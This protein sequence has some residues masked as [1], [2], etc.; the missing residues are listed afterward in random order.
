[1]SREHSLI[2]RLLQV[3]LDPNVK[4]PSV[5]LGSYV[6]DNSVV[7][8][9]TAL[10]LANIDD[11]FIDR[12]SMKDCNS[13]QSQVKVL[14]S[15]FEKCDSE[16]SRSGLAPDHSEIC[17]SLLSVVQRY[18]STVI[19]CPELFGQ[20]ERSLVKSGEI[21]S[22]ML[23]AC[24]VGVLSVIR[25]CDILMVESG[26]DSAIEFTTPILMSIVNKIITNRSFDVCSEQS[27]GELNSLALFLK[28]S[29]NVS[30]LICAILLPNL[31]PLNLP[32]AM[33]MP[34][35]AGAV[36]T[37]ASHRN[38]FML[39]TGTLIGRLLMPSTVDHVLL[40]PASATANC[41]KNVCFSNLTRR[42]VVDLNASVSQVRAQ[43]GNVIDG[44]LSVIE[45]L[46][47]ANEQVRFAVLR[48]FATAITNSATRSTMGWA[49]QMAPHG[50]QLAEHLVSPQAAASLGGSLGRFRAVT[51][52]QSVR[53]GGLLSSGTCLNLAWTIFEMCKPIK[54][55]S[56]LDEMFL[57]SRGAG[58][59][60]GA[61]LT[62]ARLGDAERVAAVAP[63]DG[64]AFKTQIFWL[65]V[66]AIHTLVLPSTKEAEMCIQCASVFHRDKKDGP[67]ND[68]YGEFHCF[69]A[70][71]SH[72]RFVQALAHVVNLVLAMLVR[73]AGSPLDIR[74]QSDTMSD[75]L[76]ILPSC[77]MEEIVELLE[78][79]RL[80][81]DVGK[82]PSNR[83]VDSLETDLF[84]QFLIWTLGS[85]QIRNPN[86]RGKAAK[87]LVSLVKEPRFANRLSAPFCV[88]NLL[89][90]CIRVFSAVEKTKQS[91][92]DIRM[93]VKFEL[94][95][96]IQQLFE[97]LLNYEDHRKELSSFVVEFRE[98]FYKFAS[99]LLN[100]TTYLL[101]EGLDTLIAIRAGNTEATGTAGL[102]VDRGVEEADQ[103]EAGEDMY[104]RSRHDPKE[105]CKQYMRMGHQTVSTLHQMCKQTCAVLVDDK[106]V[107]DQMIACC[108]DPCL[109]RLVGP[110]C[111][112]L[113]GSNS[114]VADFTLFE[115]DP[116]KLL[117]H[118]IEMYVYLARRAKERVAKAVSEDLRYYRPETL[119]KAV[120]I[121]R[122]EHLVSPEILKEFEDL[123]KCVNES[124]ANL[125]DAMSGVEV[126]DEYLDPVMAEIM[127]D[128]VLLPTSNNIMD[129][130]HIMRIILSDDHDPFNRQPL[131]PHDLIPQPELQAQIHAFCH[132]HNIP[133]DLHN[134]DMQ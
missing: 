63:T 35:T 114:V 56:V 48:W 129:R 128:P 17:N 74:R 11:I 57:V 23:S 127:V 121:A 37:Q 98:D 51:T 68:A 7:N 91:Y 102:G 92:Y 132:K 80:M 88:S 75:S 14:L 125:A 105:H 94:R 31:L 8:G 108:L 124:A 2:S 117:N 130:K 46:V 39:Q 3:S 41:A 5:Y 122:R 49:Q 118:I 66:S 13:L 90:A 32:M 60:L 36:P 18:I 15:I 110:K 4:G 40:P 65:A 77:M 67:M 78:F 12:L 19:Q 54:L 84:L 76:T 42:T 106:V 113:K 59:L 52:M 69:E 34:T 133:M 131:K 45:P 83:L 72:S 44:V 71:Y 95:I 109:D 30:G 99:Q 55:D 20:A 100:D 21:I 33:K 61:L 120:T 123:A 115:F 119:R 64:G 43:L 96:P 24:E 104:R 103:N 47:R 25:I 85:D 9:E 101:E 79:Y 70:V 28:Q 73:C 26:V 62:E 87:V 86:I 16:L 111:L 126:P 82:L 93:H 89:P 134:V 10:T 50:S 29:R 58:E 107:L 53:M 112:Q 27:L 6:G 38:V 22:S 97:L 116:K 1:M 81:K